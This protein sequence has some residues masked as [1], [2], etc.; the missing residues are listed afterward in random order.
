MSLSLDSLRHPSFEADGVRVILATGRAGEADIHIER[1]K[2]AGIEYRQLALHCTGFVLDLRHIDCPS[3][4]IQRSDARGRDRPALPFSFAYR[5]ADGRLEM[6]ITGADA[7][8]WSPLIKRLRG[9]QPAGTVDL[10]LVA[11]RQRAQLNLAVRKLK[12]G[13]RT[14]DIAGEGIDLSLNATATRVGE[15]WHWSA[16]FDWP[17]GELYVAPWYRRAGLKA[18]ATGTLT[19]V[20]LTMEM[21]RLD[22]AGIGSAT[23]ALNWDR[24]QGELV[25]WGFVT[26]PLELA[27]AFREWVQPWLDQAAVPKVRA[28]GQVRFAGAWSHGEWRS[29]Y[30]G[31]DNA[32][33][34]DGT[35]YLEL[36]GMNAH[37]PWEKGVVS[38][39]EFS[40]AGGRLG[41][42]P[43]GGFRIPVTLRDNE[44]NFEKL[45]IPLLD[46]RLYVDELVATRHDDGW[47]GQFAGGIEGLSMPKLTSALKLP[48]MDGSLTARIPRAI[49]GQQAL[50][51][52]GDLLIE[53]FDG[54]IVATG[55][56][57]LDPL[58]PTQRF[59]ADVTARNLDLGML[60]RT[61]SFGSILG[62]FDADI[63]GLELN[64]WQPV[65]FDARVRSSA[66]DYRRSISRGALRDISALGG[67]A[68]AAAVQASP[69]GFFNTFDYE[70]IGFGCSLRQ[71]VC[72]FDGLEP[73]G[74]GYVIVKGSGLPRVEVIGYNRRID[75]NLLVSRIRAVIAGKSKAVIE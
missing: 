50:S 58:K 54:R 12:F 24:R 40:V 31:L 30:A 66:G 57:V 18:E 37:I 41:E 75:W 16:Q 59:L 55:L 22:I 23:A 42:L 53:V 68:G 3:G 1:L 65:R 29:F 13:N 20:A 35:D 28:S 63:V 15:G 49:Y 27:T 73:A 7:V 25:N 19:A 47:R 4:E 9:W 46:G 11:D 69:A 39:A 14:G 6:A 43:L 36:R 45:S 26:E 70:R 5:F 10:K 72:Q 2:L 67:A 33:L 74:E 64:G 8:S 62:R 38:E 44:A 17:A 48:R 56:K 34:V 71:S 51:L 52:D 60:T 21:A 61:F 32:T